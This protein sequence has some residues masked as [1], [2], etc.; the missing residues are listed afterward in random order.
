MKN[1]GLLFLAFLNG[2]NGFCF[3]DAGYIVVAIICFA[4]ML[5]CILAFFGLYYDNK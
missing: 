2:F 4:L 5:F 3:I 1:S